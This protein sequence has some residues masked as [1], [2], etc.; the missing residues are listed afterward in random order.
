MLR[1]AVPNKGS[2]S[3]PAADMLHEAGY[4]QRRESKEL[5]VVDPT[6][7]VEFFYLRP[8]DIAIYV[9]S[10]KLDIGITGRDLLIDSGADAEEI[11]P[12]GFARS[13]FR[14]A[15]KPGT[16]NGIDDLKGR[17][18][19]TSYEGI[20]AAHLADRGVDASVVHLDGAV[21][22]A[23]ELGVAE[24]IAD[25]VETGTSLR[26]AGLE[27][28]GEPIM[29]SEAV[30]IRRSGAEPDETTEPKV[31][32]FLRRL[33]GVLVAR[34]YVMMDYDCRVEQLEKAVALTPGLESP[35]VSPLHNE[36]WVAV[37]A[38]V[39]A[40]EAQRIMDDLYEIGA[41]AILTTAIHACRL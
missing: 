36:G 32:Q 38:M 21:E 34:T 16:A 26:N 9:S 18:V 24:V 20:V 40:K 35:T 6:N 22:T 3:G 12:L 39:P 4:Q 30:V 28:F 1:I 13:T 19:A 37:R 15:G 11:L 27:V 33:Q 8:R 23:I 31:Q 17:T 2:L 7:E 41:R 5:R 14:F 10:G 25:V 29:K